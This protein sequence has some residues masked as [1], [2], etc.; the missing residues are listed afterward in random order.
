[1]RG[2]VLTVWEGPLDHDLVQQR[3]DACEDVSP[4]EHLLAQLHQLSDRVLPISDVLLQ[5]EA[6]RESL[7]S[8]GPDLADDEKRPEIRRELARDR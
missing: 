6:S 5:L 3:N 8:E 1:M 7:L 4:A 2:H